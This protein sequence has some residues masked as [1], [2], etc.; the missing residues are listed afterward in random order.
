MQDV[1][2]VTR[3]GPP[4]RC[5]EPA[6][7]ALFLLLSK[8]KAFATIELAFER[9][10]E[11]LNSK[12][13]VVQDFKCMT[14]LAFCNLI[15]PPRSVRAD[16]K[17]YRQSPRPSLRVFILKELNAAVGAV[18]FRDYSDSVNRQWLSSA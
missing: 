4:I 17:W 3:W 6:S 13:K 18:W 7:N 12:R 14:S 1:R 2:D 8:L 11:V 5:Q 16:P 9:Y 10:P 15:G